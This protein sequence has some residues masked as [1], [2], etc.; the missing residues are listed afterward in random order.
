[1]CLYAI[2]Q[3]KRPQGGV[4]AIEKGREEEKGGG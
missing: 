2:D 3:S 1:M 4:E